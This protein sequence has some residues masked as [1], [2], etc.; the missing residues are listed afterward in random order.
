MFI[1]DHV[2][3]YGV[4][5]GAAEFLKERRVTP[6]FFA[7]IS[8]APEDC[9]WYPHKGLSPDEVVQAVFEPIADQMPQTVS[10]LSQ[11]CMDVLCMK[12]D[13]IWY[14]LYVV[15]MWG[16]DY[17]L[18]I[19]GQPEESPALSREAVE[20]GWSLPE[21]LQEFYQ[22]HHG[23]GE[24][25]LIYAKQ[26]DDR[27]WNTTSIKPAHRL[28]LLTRKAEGEEGTSYLPGDV[29]LFFHDGGGDYYG[30]LKNSHKTAY[31]NHEENYI[32]DSLAGDFFRHMDE[33]FSEMFL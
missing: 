13:G 10:L 19:G 2:A 28:E 12:M 23:F 9:P 7:T 1:T 16:T 27:L 6:E 5:K 29:L 18:W 21:S 33:F 31:F 32:E 3:Q 25:D 4:E 26:F 15:K 20:A 30:I 11:N 24:S 17:Y 22:V 8:N 14:L